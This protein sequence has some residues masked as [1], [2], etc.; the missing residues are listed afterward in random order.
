M[1]Y[2]WTKAAESEGGSKKMDE[3]WH[4]CRV[5]GVYTKNKDGKRYESKAGPFFIVGVENDAGE[6]ASMSLWATEKA[7]WKIM[8][9]LSALG[10]KPDELE[11]AGVE[12]SD[13]LSKG[14]AERWFVGRSGWA[15]VT[16]SGQYANVEFDHED[17]VPASVLA[18]QKPVTA[19]PAGAVEALDDDDIPF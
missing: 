13:F 12:P 2:N 9:Q 19:A 5:V 8:A 7:D 17:N 15:Y 16:H 11:K 4:Y 3:G 18:E 14:T 10:V 1:S 6:S